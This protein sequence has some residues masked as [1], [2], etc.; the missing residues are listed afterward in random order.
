MQTKQQQYSSYQRNG[1]SMTIEEWECDGRYD[2]WL[3]GE[4]IE[5]HGYIIEKENDPW[6]L[7]FG[8]NYR[9]FKEDDEHVHF[10]KTITEAKECIM[11]KL[12]EKP[13]HWVRMKG[14]AA[15]PFHFIE[16]AIKFA[17]MWNAVEYHFA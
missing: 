15:V 6:P 12:M 3:S 11:D 7:K 17:V 5:F 1:G 13:R 10:S 14:R 8:L 9:W 16:D 2:A 4:K